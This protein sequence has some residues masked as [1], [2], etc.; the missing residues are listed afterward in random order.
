MLSM[1]SSNW[2]KV[3]EIFNSALELPPEE[4]SAYL[5]DACGADNDLRSEVEKLLD[6]YRS[7]FMEAPGDQDSENSQFASGAKL[8]RYEIVRLLG[9][10]GMGEVYL[11]KDGQLGRRVALK[12]LNR[13]YANR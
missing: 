5:D 13:E 9:T 3:K 2:Q 8:G 1:T 12:I 11:A 10:G 7:R 6:S 4:R